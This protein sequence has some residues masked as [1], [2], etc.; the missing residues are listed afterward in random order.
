MSKTY[1]IFTMGT[2]PDFYDAMDWRWK[3]ESMLRQST[4]KSMSYVHPPLLYQ[5]LENCN[6]QELSAAEC[7]RWETGRLLNSDIVVVNTDSMD[8][9]AICKMELAL[10]LGIVFGM[11]RLGKSITVVGFGSAEPNHPWLKNCFAHFEKKMEDAV[12]YIV[13]L[14]LV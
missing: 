8:D 5:Y 6:L 3:L 1:Q 2:D 11:N 13:N 4:D 9:S 12:D 7:L 14:A 10:E